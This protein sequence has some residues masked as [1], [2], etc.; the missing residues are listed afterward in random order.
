[1][2]EPFGPAGLPRYIGG[3]LIALPTLRAVLVLRNLP[4][5]T[6]STPAQKPNMGRFAIAVAITLAYLFALT[7]GGVP[8]RYL[9]C[10]FLFAL[11]ATLTDMK[12]QS[13]GI[14]SV[15]AVVA[16]FELTYLFTE[17]LTIILPK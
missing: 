17:V 4:N 7:I 3:I 12:P 15:I 2:F 16:S 6:G 14:A 10:A 13:L 11:A 1:M 9:T 8:F 5:S